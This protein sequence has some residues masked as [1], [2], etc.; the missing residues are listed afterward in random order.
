V[1]KHRPS[2]ATPAATCI[3]SYIACDSM[4]IQA[5]L[6]ECLLYLII[7]DGDGHSVK[8]CF[9]TGQPLDRDDPIDTSRTYVAISR[10]GTKV[11]MY[12][13]SDATMSVYQAA[14]GVVCDCDELPVEDISTVAA[15]ATFEI[16]H[17]VFLDGPGWNHPTNPYVFTSDGSKIIVGA[18]QYTCTVWDAHT[19]ELL[20]TLGHPIAASDGAS[21]Y[22]HY[23]VTLSPDGTKA[24]F[25]GPDGIQKMWEL[26][27]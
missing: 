4:P 16:N 8:C 17:D 24:V 13:Q 20:R 21:D 9:K 6:F 26:R 7:K 5:C 27:L 2:G 19:G 12:N 14:A 1:G 25:A 23:R 3:H 18:T 22:G 15:L 10:D 11:A